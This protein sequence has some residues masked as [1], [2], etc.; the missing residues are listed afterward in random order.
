MHQGAMRIKESAAQMQEFYCAKRTIFITL[1]GDRNETPLTRSFIDA[2]LAH[3]PAFSDGAVERGN[4]HRRDAVCL[5]K[6]RVGQTA[7][8]A[9]YFA[10]SHLGRVAVLCAHCARGKTAMA[11]RATCARAKPRRARARVLLPR[12]AE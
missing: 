4:G 2:C 11:A 6:R 9:K 3:A 1:R 7:G 12:L 5:R 10:H 8:S